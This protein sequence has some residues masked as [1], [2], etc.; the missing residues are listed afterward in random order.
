MAEVK[1]LDP[2][3]T[4]DHVG[5]IPMFLFDQDPRP[6]KEQFNERY[7]HGGGWRPNTGWTMRKEDRSLKYPGDPRLHPLAEMK[8]RDETILVYEYGIVAIVQPDGSF[9]ASRM[10]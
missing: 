5:L 10:D 8:L 3:A 9:E 2:R 6:A 7:S 4:E 1:Y